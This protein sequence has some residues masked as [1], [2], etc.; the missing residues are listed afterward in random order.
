MPLLV[1]AAEEAVRANLEAVVEYGAGC[2]HLP[3][4]C[5]LSLLDDYVVL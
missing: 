2:S 1:L 5:R 3:I 4:V